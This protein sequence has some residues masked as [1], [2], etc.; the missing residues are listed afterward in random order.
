MVLYT[1]LELQLMGHIK[2][3]LEW[4]ES[5]DPPYDLEP[6]KKSVKQIEDN[7]KV[8]TIIK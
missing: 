3:L 4:L 5:Y 8:D 1:Q 6:M 7:L 2:V